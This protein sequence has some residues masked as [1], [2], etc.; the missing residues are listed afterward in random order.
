MK[1]PKLLMAA[2]D[3]VWSSGLY[4]PKG[5]ETWC[6]IATNAVLS[7]LGCDL[8]EGFTADGM[9]DFMR[10]HQDF[11]VKPMADCQVLVNEGTILVAGLTGAEL[12]QEHGHVVTLTPGVED[13]SGKWDKKTPLCMNLG[14]A[15]TCFRA[16]GL[17][18]AFQIPPGIFAWVPSL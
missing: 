7:A 17:N 6:N 3:K 12:K 15:G 8:M 2:Q 5:D 10:T 18:W 11:L 9:V 14:R 4:L 1:D 13:Y 16:K